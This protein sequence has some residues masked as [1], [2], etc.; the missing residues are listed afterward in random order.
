M[1]FN[2]NLLLQV[3]EVIHFKKTVTTTHLS[4]IFIIFNKSIVNQ[5]PLQKHL[6]LILD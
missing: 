5:A 4:L 3:T 1:S 2:P 6:W